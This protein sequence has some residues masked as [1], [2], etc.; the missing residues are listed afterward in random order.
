MPVSCN[1]CQ[2]NESLDNVNIFVSAGTNTL[3]SALSVSCLG[4]NR[5]KW[6]EIVPNKWWR[7]KFPLYIFLSCINDQ[8]HE[9]LGIILIV[10]SIPRTLHYFEFSW[11]GLFDA[12]ENK[13]KAAGMVQPWVELQSKKFK[14]FFSFA[15][16]PM[17]LQLLASPIA[18]PKGELECKWKAEVVVQLCGEVPGRSPAGTCSRWLGGKHLGVKEMIY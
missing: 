8:C 2:L 4:Q 7:R 18:D 15:T 1:G 10:L 17:C 9:E 14:V 3:I 11:E 12:L 5:L 6:H 13:W 16:T